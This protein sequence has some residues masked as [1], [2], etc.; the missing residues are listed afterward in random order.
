MTRIARGTD[1]VLNRRDR[2]QREAIAPLR[3]VPPA[4]IGAEPLAVEPTPPEPVV[5]APV[6]VAPPS[7]TVEDLPLD[8][9]AA[10]RI[11][12]EPTEKLAA[13]VLQP[14]VIVAMAIEP[15]VITPV[16]VDSIAHF[17]EEEEAFFAAGDNLLDE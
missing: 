16:I 3:L 13:P 2:L 15:P 12:T 7:V 10:K 5:V 9:R 11:D 14:S 17:T 6:V 8:S 4:T 1:P